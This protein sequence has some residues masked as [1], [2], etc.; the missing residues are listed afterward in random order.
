LPALA[1]EDRPTSFGVVLRRLRQRASLTQAEL[2]RRAKL[3]V[4]AIGALERGER[5][6]PHPSTVRALATALELTGDDRAELFD[7]MRW[8]G[9]VPADNGVAACDDPLENRQRAAAWELYV[10]LITR[11]AVVELP[12]DQGLL[13]DALTSLYTL[14]ETTRRILKQHGVV[15]ADGGQNGTVKVAAVAVWVLNGVIRPVLV[16][17]HP[18]L[19]DYESQRPPHVPPAEHERAWARR[20]EL[21]A[22]LSCLRARLAEQARV[23][24]AAARIP[25]L[26]V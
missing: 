6:V 10:E 17:W 3:S 22:V 2:G 18:A 9:K 19:L 13:R 20:S 23:L 24:A 16:E 25:D 4:K 15:L 8:R 21:Q 14:F 7:S 26:D 12:S 11:I 5:R 1:R